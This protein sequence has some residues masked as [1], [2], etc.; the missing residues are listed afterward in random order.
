MPG[1]RPSTSPPTRRNRR[2]RARASS[3][4]PS[5]ASRCAGPRPSSRRP[6]ATRASP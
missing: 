5:G 4:R 6:R 3:P 1:R 2:S